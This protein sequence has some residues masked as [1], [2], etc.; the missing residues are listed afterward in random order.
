MNMSRRIYRE[1][2][3]YFFLG[4]A[5]LDTLSKLL[6]SS[7]LLYETRARFLFIQGDGRSHLI[8]S[9]SGKYY[10]F[11]ARLFTKFIP[12]LFT[13]ATM[14][15]GRVSRPAVFCFSATPILIN[16]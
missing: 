11:N 15:R 6:S 10:C 7:E 4:T 1:K 9:I 5:L 8:Y 14:G 13:W 12:L 3:T 16:T 2:D